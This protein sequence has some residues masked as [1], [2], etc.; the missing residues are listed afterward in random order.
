MKKLISVLL[1]VVLLIPCGCAKTGAAV[2]VAALMGPTGMG[3]ANMMEKNTGRYDFT[4]ASAPDQVAAAVVSGS[5]D[6]AA[7]PVNL[8][9]ALYQKTQGAVQVL[10]VN[11]LGVLYIL[12]NGDTVHS[13]A[14]LEGKTLYAT[15][16]A[17][18]PEYVLNYLLEKNG[19]AGKV[20]VEYLPEHTELAAL[21]RTG[22]AAIG[23]LPEPN[24]TSVLMGNAKARIALD[25]TEQ[26]SK[27]ADAELVQGCIL[28]RRD[29]A[30]QNPKAVQTFLKDY[31]NSVD[32]A[33]QNP[34][35]AA[36]MMERQGIVPKAAIAE[37]ALPNCN[38]CLIT[39][40]KMR[41]QMDGM[42]QV[43]FEANPASVGG[44]LPDEGFYYEK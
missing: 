36:D 23:M 40:A 7:V 22:D 29:F 28:V 37:A 10:A 13:L 38:I 16:Q 11:T 39:G 4:L 42:L 33:L 41:Q 18:T 8:A 6:I 15:G 21:L 14:D 9:A 27:V 43:L 32:F 35:E 5:V 17:A 20:D 30:E 19:L 31:G 24:V 1:A 26:W 2:R 12:E 25:L 44:S 3:M 34:A